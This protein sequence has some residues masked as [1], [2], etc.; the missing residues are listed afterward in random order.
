MSR[1]RTSKVLTLYAINV[2]FN[3]LLYVKDIVELALRGQ[4]NNVSVKTCLKR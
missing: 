4:A 3:R 1:K 2:L